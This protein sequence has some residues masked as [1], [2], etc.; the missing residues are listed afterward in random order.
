MT[1]PINP[2]DLYGQTVEFENCGETL[3][4]KV[5]LT[6]SSG[7]LYIQPD[8]D[9]SLCPDCPRALHTGYARFVHEV[10]LVQ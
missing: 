7:R 3:T 6:D 4:G 1:E 9:E 10:R 2:H 5:K 8:R